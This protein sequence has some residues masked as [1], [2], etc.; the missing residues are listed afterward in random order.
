[1]IGPLAGIRIV[2]MAGLGP[3]PFAGMML[4]DHGAEVIRVER[5]GKPESSISDPTKDVLLRSRKRLA[6]DLKTADGLAVVRALIKSS[7]GLIEGFRP[8]VM[9][10]LGLGPDSVMQMNERLVYGRVT[11]WGQTGPLA[12]AAGHDIN[13]IA[14][15]G[16][17]HAFGRAGTAPTPPANIAGDF[18]G[19]GM[20]LA[21][22]MLAALLHVQRGGSGQVIDCAMTE[23]SAL[24]M[25]MM[26]G[27]RAMGWWNRSRGTNLLDTGAHF[28]ESYETADGKWIALGAIEPQFYALLRDKLGLNA[29][30]DFDTQ[31]DP[32]RW[33]RLKKKLAVLFL[34]RTREAWCALLEGS[35]TCF[36]PVLDFDEAAAHPHNI[37]RQL[38]V[39]AGGVVQP[40]PT[41]RYSGLPTVAPRMAGA[42]SDA[43]PLLEELGYSTARVD[44]LRSAG[45]VN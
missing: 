15:S 20:M 18:G 37:A 28:Y 19:G 32:A 12:Q 40:A 44:A 21:F 31:L 7:D 6:V 33:E 17:L 25:A 41:P 24:L 8:G 3:A 11:G 14:L 9:E 22:A 30:P 36:A 26:W 43:G 16:A 23:G 2:E 27:F 10:R 4:A 34:T 39:E 38:L 42:G 5:L 13:Y 1:M 45:V 35:D 29:D